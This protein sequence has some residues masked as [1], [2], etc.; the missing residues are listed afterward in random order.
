MELGAWLRKVGLEQYETAFREA[1]IE[2]DL[3]SDLTDADLEK[4]GLPLGHRKRFL[5]AVA[6]TNAGETTAV[7]S[8]AKLAV[9]PSIGASPDVAERRPI[10]VMFCDL[11]GSTSL[12]ANLDAEDWRDL[13]GAYLDAASKAVTEC[14]GHVL[15]K[16][17]DG[18]MA[19]FGYPKAQE[20]DAERAARAAL[21]ILR[22]LEELNAKNAAR[23]KPA[24]AARIG[25]ESGPVI[26]DSSGEVFGDAPNIAARVQSAADPGTLLV[27]TTVQRQVAGLFVVEDKGAYELKGVQGKRTLYRLVRASGGARRLGA[28]AVTPLIGRGEEITL[29]MR[30]WERTSGGEGQF[31]QIVGE[32][33]LGK[34]RLVDEFRARLAGVAHTWVEWASSQLLQN[35]PL[36]PVSEWGRQRFGGPEL[37]AQTRF[38]DLESTLAQVR[39]DPIENAPLIAPLVDIPVPEAHVLKMAPEE[40]RRRQLS[41]MVAWIL[42]GARQQPVVLAFEDLHWADPTTLDLMKI[43]ADRGAHAP[44]LIVATTRPE[45]RAPWTTRSHHGVIS[46]APLDGAEVRRMVG[47]IAER[48]ALPRDVVEKLSERTGGVPLFVEE[49]TRLML[50]GGAQAIPPTLQQSLAARLDRLGEAREI[51]QVGAVLGAAFA[52]TLLHAVSDRSAMAL[53]NALEKLCDS[54]LLFVD[55][56]VP[57]SSYSFKHA[58]I[59]DAAYESL[60]K[61]RRQSL[62]RR[63]AEALLAVPDAQPELVAYH[64]TEAKEPESA[65]AHWM[66]AGQQAILRSASQE[67][68]GHLEKGLSQL[69]Q[70]PD[71]PERIK[72]EIAAQRLLG[73]AS[74]AAK[75]YA[76]PETIQ[77]FDRARKLCLKIGDDPNAIPILFGFWVSELTR[78]DFANAEREV[79][80]LLRLAARVK[81]PGA[82]IAADLAAAITALHTGSFAKA[83]THFEAAICEYGSLT[84][85]EANGLAYEYG[86]DLGS[87]SYSYG[88]WCFW[89]LG[90][91]DTAL[92]MSEQALVALKRVG[93]VYS[94]ARGLYWN[95]FLRTFRR[96]R[97]A[98][99][100]LAS[101]AIDAAKERGLAMV[102]AVGRIMLAASRAEFEAAETT[103][104]EIREAMAA[105]EATGARFQRTSHLALLADLQSRAG[106]TDDALRSLR[107]AS[108]LVEQTGERF[109]EAE[110][111]RVMGNQYAK[112]SHKNVAAAEAHYT[113]SLEV[114]RSQQS[115]AL[116]L[117]SAYA[118]ARL[119]ADRGDT[120]SARSVL[121]PVYAWFT[122]GF[123]TADLQEARR[124]LE[125]LEITS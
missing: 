17:G 29:I 41:A 32:P 36:H 73:Q 106:R 34:S 24:L 8:P 30:R 56:L 96:E 60:I 53:E 35:T 113:K 58:L 19:L 45:F 85:D 16:L 6:A 112:G 42:G 77:A 99:E 33:G 3:L 83:R 12:A 11:V 63:A 52:Y 46:L 64:Y 22:A 51:A 70:T 39:L 14:G 40:L 49:L 110:I 61:N 80:E 69:A 97:L 31:V 121:S 54:D 78:A 62:H 10:T 21:E 124:L 25:L 101:A 119:L 50:E 91:P 108:N 117:R 90:Y 105:Y 43:L 59:R 107:Q 123:E 72:K 66:R 23:G 44:L 103:E 76:A 26:V 82:Q 116:E 18:I 48:H 114:A 75:G 28:R 92:R 38:A 9:A 87:A 89:L 57:H 102:A 94:R 98:A 15:K 81:D 37:E 95:S 122:E 115:R 20:N 47:A 55:G 68:I 86:L 79:G 27:T 84:V 71:G 100:Q 120:M 67:T 5:K 65:F 2:P 111:S 125:S 4:L 93:H 13:V 109:V 74:F 88:A 1:A 104:L 118:L 7:T